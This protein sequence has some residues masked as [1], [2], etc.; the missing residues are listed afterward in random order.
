MKRSILVGFLILGTALLNSCGGDDDGV[1]PD[2]TPP[3]V[4]RTYPANGAINIRVDTVI[5]AAFSEDMQAA[6][7]NDSTFTVGGVSGTVSYANKV[8]TFTPNSDLSFNTV[9]TATITTGVKDAAGNALPASYIWDFTTAEITMINGDEYFPMAEGDTWYYTDAAH[10]KIV[11]VVSGDTTINSLPCKRILENDTTAEAWSKDSTGM[12]VHLLDK[13]LWFD[14]PLK[15]PFDLVYDVPY[16]YNS[17]VYWT[18]NDT[19]YQSD[20]TGIL[21]FKGYLTFTVGAGRFD[22]TIQLSYVTDGYSEYYAKG[23]GLLYNEDYALDS[24]YVGGV[25]YRPAR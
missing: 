10:N 24:A 9:Y 25:W 4:A 5:T 19:L 18:V 22:S 11:R 14:P 6:T 7:I 13:I 23:V 20:I 17:I 21:K 2:I 1:K 12:Y 15:I 3:A 8:A 16:N